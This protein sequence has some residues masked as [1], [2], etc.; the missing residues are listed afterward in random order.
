MAGTQLAPAAH[1]LIDAI[2]QE[3]PFLIHRFL[4]TSQAYAS[5]YSYIYH[6]Y[7]HSSIGSLDILEV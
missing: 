2:C 1:L 7:S 4:E 3:A 6:L 5:Q